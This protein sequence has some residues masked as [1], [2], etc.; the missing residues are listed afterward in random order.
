M[1]GHALTARFFI[2]YAHGEGE[3]E[4]LCDLFARSLR[5]AGHTVFVDRQIGFGS[6][7]AAEIERQ[8]RACDFFLLLLSARAL[9]SRMVLQEVERVCARRKTEGAPLILTVRVKLEGALPYRWAA[10]LD[11]FQWRAWRD[12]SDF[13]PIFRAITSAVERRDEAPAEPA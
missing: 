6:S 2:S 13:D 7:W 10:H 9:E 11:E 12:G 5:A 1:G 4:S 8:L 3:D